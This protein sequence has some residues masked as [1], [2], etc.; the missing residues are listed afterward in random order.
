MKNKRNQSQSQ[1]QKKTRSNPN[2]SP[3][4]IFKQFQE[5]IP[6]LDT[7]MFKEQQQ[8]EQAR[9][10]EMESMERQ[11]EAEARMDALKEQ[12][13]LGE[14]QAELIQAAARPVLYSQMASPDSKIISK[15][16]SPS[17]KQLIDGI[18]WSEIIGPPRAQNPHKS[19][20][21]NK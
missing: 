3:A 20:K 13:Q 16:M 19:V 9:K 12:Q 5:R 18:I 21:N 15:P 14:K 10:L 7:R 11:R 2:P 17:K 4:E 6:Q 8:A 1:Q